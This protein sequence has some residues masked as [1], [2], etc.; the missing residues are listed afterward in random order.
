MLEKNI[1]S[2]DLM[3]GD[4]APHC[5]LEAAAQFNDVHFI[6]ACTAD[7]ANIIKQYDIKNFET[8]LADVVLQNGIKYDTDALNQSS[9]TAAILQVKNKRA[10]CVISAGPTGSLVVL[11]KQHLGLVANIHKA[12]LA[13]IIPTTNGASIMLDLGAN[14]HCSSDDLVGFATLGVD[15]AQKLTHVKLPSVGF[16]NIGQEIGKGPQEIQ[17]AMNRFALQYS[18]R[19]AFVEPHDILTGK[20]DVIIVSGVLGN[21]I[22]KASEGVL[23]F[24]KHS[25]SMAFRQNLFTK[26]IG[27][28]SKNIIKNNLLDPKKFNGAL[29]AGING[30]VVKA[31]GRS[32]TAAYAAAIKFAKHC[33]KTL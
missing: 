13:R 7:C 32:D 8:V 30:C 29:L 21:C 1:I 9:L 22:L 26:I 11:S 4:N 24:V 28:F 3:G 23:K 15:L 6:F 25:L 19:V 16:I 33:I 27:F 18:G 20:F 12:A 31:H 2:I 17:D 5:I 14:L 10:Q